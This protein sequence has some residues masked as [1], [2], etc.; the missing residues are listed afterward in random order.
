MVL[1]G[2]LG[3]ADQLKKINGQ[4]EKVE[5]LQRH[6][7]MEG[8]FEVARANLQRRNA[9]EVDKLRNDQDDEMRFLGECE[10]REMTGKMRAVEVTQRI[11][12]EERDYSK[13]V[14]KKFHRDAE[15]VVSAIVAPCRD[16]SSD[17]PPLARGKV[18]PPGTAA[19]MEIRKR[20]PVSRLPLGPLALKHYRPPSLV[21][22]IKRRS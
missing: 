16:A 22:S 14:T 12:G 4:R 8:S 3:D 2:Q 6:R 20:I 17:L 1:C 7:E 13:F 18:I 21:K 11:L 10:R 5:L 9:L 19:M 15:F